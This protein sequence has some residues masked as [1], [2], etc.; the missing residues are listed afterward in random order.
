MNSPKAH[1]IETAVR[2]HGV[3]AATRLRPAPALPVRTSRRRAPAPGS[4]RAS[5]KPASHRGALRCPM[6]RLLV[7]LLLSRAISLQN[8]VALILHLRSQRIAIR[9]STDF[10]DPLVHF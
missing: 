2:V 6:P 8:R 9:F 10:L 4:I 7:V 1:L 3:G 5:G